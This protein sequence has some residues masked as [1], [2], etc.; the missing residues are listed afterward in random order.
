VIGSAVGGA[1]SFIGVAPFFI[2]EGEGILGVG[3]QC[4]ILL[5]CEDLHTGNIFNIDEFSFTEKNIF[6]KGGCKVIPHVIY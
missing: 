6:K 5:G 1:S 4:L 2:Y 3:F